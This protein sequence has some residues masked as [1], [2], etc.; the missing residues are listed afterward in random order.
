MSSLQSKDCQ[1]DN[2]NDFPTVKEQSYL[3]KETFDEPL[4]E[5][6]FIYTGFFNGFNVELRSTEDMELYKMGWF[7][8][9]SAS[10]SK[11][12]AHREFPIMR[13]RQFQKRN[14][15]YTKFSGVQVGSQPDLFLKAVNKLTAKIIIEGEIRRKNKHLVVLESSDGSH[16]SDDGQ[17]DG[18]TVEVS[19]KIPDMDNIAVVVPNSESELEDNTNYFHNFKAE[20]CVNHTKLQEKLMLTL[21]EAFFLVY[22]Y[23]CMQ[24]IDLKN[25]KLNIEQTWKLFNESDKKFIAKYVVYHYFRSK[26]YIVKP[27]TKFGGDYC[28][29]RHH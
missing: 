11:P 19:S 12:V 23:G 26:G 3:V 10:R 28:K 25:D 18:E 15:L 13:K 27:G 1:N 6:T 22:G 29:Y 14:E 24:I 7:G 20:C 2:P 16:S 17:N 4:D 21:Q 5:L 8:K 9:G